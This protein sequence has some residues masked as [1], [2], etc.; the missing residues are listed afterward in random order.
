MTVRFSWWGA[1]A[2]SH[3]WLGIA[4]GLLFILWFVSGIAMMYVRMPEVTPAERY[5][6]LTALDPALVQLSVGEA[7]RLAGLEG[8]VPV[9]LVM[10]ADRPVYR[11]AGQSPATIFADRPEKLHG[12]TGDQARLFAA[13]FASD[14]ART[15]QHAGMV[16]IPDQWTLQSRAHLPLHRIALGDDAGTELYVSSR[17]GEVVMD[18]TRRERLLAYLG[19]VAHWL[20]LPILRRNGPLWTDVIIWSSLAGCLLCITGLA[21]GLLR[22]APLRG[23]SIRGGRAMTPYAGW[24]KWH[25]YAG[26]IFGLITLT[27][28]FSGLLSMGP[29]PLLSS[30]GVTAE[31]RRAVV[32]TPPPFDAMSA[33]AVQAA[34]ARASQSLTP[35]EL[36]LITFRSAAYWIASESPSRQ[37]LVP[38]PD[39]ER[40]L[41]SF[42]RHTMESI[43][44]EA[45]PGVPL[46]DWQWIDEYDD[47][48]YDRTRTRPLPVLRARYGDAEQTWLYLD[49]ARGAIALVTRRA[50]RLNR[51][52]YHGLHSLDFAWLHNRRPLWDAVV[53]LLSL[54]G[55][56]G[57][58]TSLLPAW[59]RLRRHGQSLFRIGV[60]SALRADNRSVADA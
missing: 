39:P 46:V 4:G 58:V 10:L 22:F 40:V 8:P 37:V 30:D 20:Y 36:T 32:G 29:F 51:W 54:G 21:A 57:A 16:A 18:T 55:L 47:H 45:M 24:M 41:Q 25:H 13:A 60:R 9:Q 15:L 1:L 28:T 42:D 33:G 52:L 48:Y 14:H 19:P 23:F 17:T 49:P 7:A 56:A 6:H 5:G 3:R 31:Q 27:W 44:R 2:F 12:V 43:A 38:S 11:F 50:D 26:L 35:K 59:R 53:I 34:I